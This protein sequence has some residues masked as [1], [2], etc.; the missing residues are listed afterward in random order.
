MP[1]IHPLIW[2]GCV[3]ASVVLLA[4]GNYLLG[5]VALATSVLALWH[6]GTWPRRTR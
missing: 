3:V 5:G 1:R 2:V 6:W 4:V